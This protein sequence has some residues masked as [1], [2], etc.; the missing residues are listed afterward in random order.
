[1][2]LATD[3]HSGTL[4]R[5][6]NGYYVA[7]HWRYGEVAKLGTVQQAYDREA[8]RMVVITIERII[9]GQFAYKLYGNLQSP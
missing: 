8:R 3:T 4:E 2:L 1:M 6:C 5:D 9:D 7:A